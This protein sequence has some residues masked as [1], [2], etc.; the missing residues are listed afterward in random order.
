MLYFQKTTINFNNP[1]FF[2][3]PRYTNVAYVYIKLKSNEN[4][5]YLNIL[6]GNI[7]P[8]THLFLFVTIHYSYS[9]NILLQ[10][11]Y[12]DI[13]NKFDKVNCSLLIKKLSEIYFQGE[14]LTLLEMV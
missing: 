8:S 6:N 9:D 14:T 7:L 3:V 12:L 5:V 2:N 4:K 11:I 10:S 1:I 13:C